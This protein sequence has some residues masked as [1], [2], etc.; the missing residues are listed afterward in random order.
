MKIQLSTCATKPKADTAR[1]LDAILRH[2]QSASQEAGQV[3]DN[4]TVVPFIQETIEK[5]VP[6]VNEERKTETPENSKSTLP[7]LVSAANL[8][9]EVSF[10]DI[11]TNI[12]PL[13]QLEES[14]IIATDD[15]GLLL[16][17]QHVAHERILFDKYRALENARPADSQNLLMPETFDLTPAQTAA[18]DSVAEELEAYGFALMRLSG[19]TVA[20]KAVPADLP[21]GEAR[22]ML[23]EVLETVDAEKR[24]STRATFRD[25]VAASLACRAAIKI[26]TPLALEKMRWL[27]DRLLLTS[28]P[29]TC[30]HGR[31]VILRLATRDIEKGFHRS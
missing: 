19:R 22:N 25:E 16:I 26:N 5:S 28:S 10:E 13:G 9:R 30:P 3:A 14:F 12:R 23:A 8:V 6:V 1:G 2:T 7:P 31:P 29:T 18:F 11:S 17:D 4:A 27:I 21:A 20:I 15:E 24:G